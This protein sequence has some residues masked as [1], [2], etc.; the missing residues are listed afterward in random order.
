MKTQSCKALCKVKCAYNIAAFT[1]VL[2]LVSAGSGLA[3]SPGENAT[4]RSPLKFQA[5]PARHITKAS[6]IDETMFTGLAQT[7]LEEAAPGSIPVP[8]VAMAPTR[9]SFLAN[10]AP[11]NGATGYRLD[12]ST[13]PS[14]ESYTSSYQ[15]L[16]VGNVTSRIVGHLS[17]GRTYYYRVQPYGMSATSGASRV[18]T[19]TTTTGSGLVINPTFD[20]SVT[21]NP[22]A[23][24]IEAMITQSIALFQ[25]LLS[26]PITV[27][28]YYRY[29][30]TD[31]GGKTL[32]ADTL[33]ESD[34]S[35]YSIPWSDFIS[36]LMA[37][38]K[39]SNDNTA[40]ASLP[41]SALTPNITPSSANG[42]ALGLDTPAAT[43]SNGK[44]GS[45]QQYDGIVTL[46]S[47]SPFQFTRP[48]NAGD[49]DAKRAT[50]HETD[51][52][53]GLGSHLGSSP[54]ATDLMPQDLFSWSAAGARNYSAHG[55]R[56]FSI[57][58]GK[59][60]IVGFNQDSSADY[61]DWLSGSCPQ[62]TPYVQNAFSCMGQYSDVS[63]TSP[64]GINLDVIGYD[65]VTAPLLGNISTRGLVGTGDDVLIGGFIITGTEPKTVAIRAIGP[66]LANSNP[67]VTGTLADP[68]L[69]LHEPGGTVV[70][71]NDWMS[72]SP[73]DQGTIV[74]NGLDKYN[75]LPISN[76]ESVIIATLPPVNPSVAGSGEYTAIV[77]GNGG[78]TGVGLVEIYDLD[79]A[80]A[81]KLA[82]IS[83]RGLVQTDNNVLI[84]GFIVLGSDPANV[85]VRA[86]GPSL[87]LSGTLANPTLDLYDANGN[88]LAYN[89]DWKSTQ[90]AQIEATGLAP[91][92]DA[93][94]AILSTLVP[95]SYTAIVR[96]ANNTVGL[97][98]VEVYQLAN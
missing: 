94:S 12:V 25:S 9:G 27:D 57:D 97:A 29:A 52:I 17:A 23:A 31:P 78:G 24:A 66:S 48:T 45:G 42:R 11:V 39:T 26:D 4:S 7:P 70:T 20:S 84:G 46:N 82:N 63:A 65:L 80:S 59:T 69:E 61:G 53:L 91:T 14:F 15:G 85:V 74:A 79:Q 77:S 95:A 33:S 5:R 30:A 40:N 44:S 3:Q 88:S 55:T 72:N 1:L 6:S 47:K 93:E 58:G 98:L 75:N 68:V 13:S 21:S 81:S 87:P 51:E 92:Q 37:D 2:G 71:N 10:W 96:G 62:S 73:T 19:V 32:A 8:K 16:D 50:E 34:Y 67:P 56:Y 43:S 35:V 76:L 38:A 22:N 86:L 18:M 64:E 60:D 89:D 90:E 49:Y 36:A 28:I 83:T 54:P 41:T